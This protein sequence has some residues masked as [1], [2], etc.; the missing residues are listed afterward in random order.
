MDY[1]I[2]SVTSPPISMQLLDTNGSPVTG[3]GTAPTVT[4]SKNGAAFGSATGSVAELGTGYY[5]FTPSATDVGTDGVL[6]VRMAGTGAVTDTKELMI[7]ESTGVLPSGFAPPAYTPIGE[8]P[9]DPNAD[10]VTVHNGQ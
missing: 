6:I 3:L 4:L 8:L 5:A 9:S 7:I 10:H 1:R 2:K